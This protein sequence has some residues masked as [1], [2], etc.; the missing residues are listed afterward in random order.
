MTQEQINSMFE[1]FQG[2]DIIYTSP[3]DK[4]F[5]RFK[6]CFDY[7][8]DILEMEEPDIWDSIKEWEYSPQALNCYSVDECLLAA[9]MIL[10][11]QE[12]GIS[13]LLEPKSVIK[14]LERARKILNKKYN[15]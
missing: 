15:D 12:V 4:P 13:L 9:E 1:S 3:D 2:V 10:D 8:H 7:C 6:E 11:S 5:I 14:I